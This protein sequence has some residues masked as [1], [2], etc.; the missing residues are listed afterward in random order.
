[1][2][3]IFISS[4]LGDRPLVRRL[5]G[6]LAE[7]GVI[8][9]GS[10]DASS[11]PAVADLVVAIWSSHSVSNDTVFNDAGHA[12]ALGKLFSVNVAG[13]RTPPIFSSQQH[14]DLSALEEPDCKDLVLAIEEMAGRTAHDAPPASASPMSVQYNHTPRGPLPQQSDHLASVAPTNAMSGFAP[15]ALLLTVFVAVSAVALI[16]AWRFPTNTASSPPPS[17]QASTTPDARAPSLLAPAVNAQSPALAAN[18]QPPAPIDPSGLRGIVSRRADEARPRTRT[19]ISQRRAPIT[20]APTTLSATS[21]ARDEERA[22][23]DARA[24]DT[25]PSYARYLSSFPHG[26]HAQEAKDR[27]DIVFASRAQFPVTAL[28]E[29]SRAFVVQARTQAARAAAAAAIAKA[30]AQN[31]RETDR[32]GVIGFSDA[33]YEGQTRNGVPDGV[34]RLYYQNGRVYAGAFVRG[35]P[36]GFGVLLY[37]N[38]IR[39]EGELVA[40][41]PNARGVFWSRDGQL[42]SATGLFTEL[43]SR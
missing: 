16:T 30:T 12:V 17:A 28:E 2:V 15:T 4:D 27:R 34:G 22:F 43:I 8:V 32:L 42:V 21:A 6:L 36:Q 24:G 40:G 19:T 1:M 14:Y 23:A 25:A 33:A 31:T 35:R 13:A 26:A 38:G 3:S 11:D 10:H 18:M 5:S 39:Y 37:E 7:R 29:P 41:R 20:S 9:G